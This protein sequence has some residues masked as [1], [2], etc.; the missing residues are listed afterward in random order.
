[1]EHLPE[2]KEHDTTIIGWWNDPNDLG[3]A[4][5]R[6]RVLEVLNRRDF[7]MG[8]DP[9]YTKHYKILAK[10]HHYGRQ[11]ALEVKTEA[12]GR[13]CKIEFFQNLVVENR[14]GGYY[15]FGKRQKMPYLVGKQYEAARRAIAALIESLGGTLKLDVK[16]KGYALLKAERDELDAFHRGRMYDRAPELYNATSGAKKRLRDGDIVFFR[17]FDGRW[18]RGQTWHHINNMWWVLLPCGTVR[19]IAAFELFHRE[20]IGELR[21]RWFSQQRV[22][23][24]LGDLKERA[25]R[26]ERFEQAAVLRDVLARVA[27]LKVAA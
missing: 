17:H 11:G 27:P 16:L 9:Y 23:K 18:Q 5:F 8:R 15:D 25:V 21:G 14:N 6:D 4:A 20:D 19:N 3:V 1:M 10:Y 12:S 22:A 13:S 26:A 7:G 24:R 2:F